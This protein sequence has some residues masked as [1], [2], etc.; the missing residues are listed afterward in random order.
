MQS[1]RSRQWKTSY[2]CVCLFDSKIKNGENLLKR[3]CP[4]I[5]LAFFKWI[6]YP[7]LLMLPLQVIA[8]LLCWYSLLLHTGGV[9]KVTYCR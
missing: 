6:K 2:F 5:N 8:L 4:F 7:L 1:N 3:A 9:P